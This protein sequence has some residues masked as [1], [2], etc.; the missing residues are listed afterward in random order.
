[1]QLPNNLNK[2]GNSKLVQLALLG[3]TIYFSNKYKQNQAQAQNRVQQNQ[4]IERDNNERSSNRQQKPKKSTP[5]TFGRSLADK[6]LG[7]KS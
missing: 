7:R 3:A 4:N 6:L 5:F 1:M 2:L